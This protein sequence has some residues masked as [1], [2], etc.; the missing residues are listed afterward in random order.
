MAVTGEIFSVWRNYLWRL[1]TLEQQGDRGECDVIR[2]CK[3]AG[4]VTFVVM[5]GIRFTIMGLGPGTVIL[6]V[7]WTD[8]SQRCSCLRGPLGLLYHLNILLSL[9][10]MEIAQILKQML[11]GK[12]YSAWR[13]SFAIVSIRV[14]KSCS[15]RWYS[16]TETL[17]IV[18]QKTFSLNFLTRWS[19]VTSSLDQR[20][21]CRR[22]RLVVNW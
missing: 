5:E 8:C 11:R 21:R 15:S 6:L 14:M 13:H 9:L 12:Y 19:K 3:A 10:Y 20:G 22:C 17:S 1:M 16:N 4:S 7:P 18:R 2:N